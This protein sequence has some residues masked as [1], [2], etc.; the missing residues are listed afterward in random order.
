MDKSSTFSS[1]ARGLAQLMQLGVSTESAPTQAAEAKQILD[2]L[3]TTKFC[4]ICSGI[5]QADKAAMAGFASN[6]V[7]ELLLRSDVPVDILTCI[8]DYSKQQTTIRASAAVQEVAVA[9]YYAAIASALVF[10]GV[11]ISRHSYEDL[12]K[13][14]QALSRK[15]WLAP[16]LVK[17]FAQAEHLASK[18]AK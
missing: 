13:G 17:H 7:G 12:C 18:A 10:D 1:S 3:L 5:K 14:W 9:V 15:P 16:D 8:K 4:D 6:T 2:V 11:K